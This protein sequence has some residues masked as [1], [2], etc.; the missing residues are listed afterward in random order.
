M[1]S[2]GINSLALTAPGLIGARTVPDSNI[3]VFIYTFDF[4]G[5][6]NAKKIPATTT[7]YVYH[8]Y[9]ELVYSIFR[10]KWVI[11]RQ[12]LHISKYTALSGTGM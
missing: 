11:A 12:Y 7:N 9:G 8:I 10:P 2:V 1:H 5:S 6:N 3:R 4:M